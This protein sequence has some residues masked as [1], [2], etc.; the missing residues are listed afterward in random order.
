MRLK[1]FAYAVNHILGIGRVTDMLKLA[2]SACS[3]MTADRINMIST[4][5]HAA[6]H[7]DPVTWGNACDKSACVSY[8]ITA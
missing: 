6:I 5:Y 2:P 1:C 3:E 7:R 8:A 4:P